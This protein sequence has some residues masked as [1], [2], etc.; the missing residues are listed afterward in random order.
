VYLVNSSGGLRPWRDLFMYFQNS[1]VI[2]SVFV[3]MRLL[4]GEIYR[5]RFMAAEDRAARSGS[6]AFTQRLPL[7]LRGGELRA[8]CAEG[9]YIRAWTSLGS[10]LVLFRLKD[11]INELS[12]LEGMQVHR[13]WWVA[14][15]AI[16]GSRRENGRLFLLL[17][18][19]V[20]VPVSRPN[21]KRLKAAGWL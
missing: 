16:R 17:D 18:D 8:L 13:S 7:K 2:S 3:M 11:A 9:H 19:D 10:D 4:V 12:G 20:R 6:S 1:L 14:R 5:F 21:V 15:A